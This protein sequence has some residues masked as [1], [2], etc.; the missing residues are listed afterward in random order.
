MKKLRVEVPW[1]GHVKGH[2]VNEQDAHMHHYLSASDVCD[3]MLLINSHSITSQQHYSVSLLGGCGF[4]V[5]C[6]VVLLLND[7]L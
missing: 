1:W 4:C 6:C 5:C 7:F 2:G 3:C